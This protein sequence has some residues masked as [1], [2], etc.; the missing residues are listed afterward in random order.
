M[1]SNT[2]QKYIHKIR[3]LRIDKAHGN[4]PHQPVLLL[5]II[6]LIEQG[7]IL[8]NKITLSP[9]LVETFVKYWTKITDRKPNLALPF[10]HL[11]KRPFWHLHANPGYENAL[12]VVTQIKTVTRLRKVVAYASFDDEFFVLL[13]KPKEREIFRQTIISTYLSDFKHEIQSLIL[14]EQ[15]ISEYSQ[16]ILQQVEHEFIALQQTA[17]SESENPV[18]KRGFR[19]AIMRIYEYT[20]AVCQLHILTLD[21]QSVTEAAHIIPHKK[22]YNND[23]RNGISLCRLHHW[24]F[25]EGLISFNDNYKVIVSELMSER[26]PTEWL[27]STLH[28]QSILLPENNELYP[29]Q[30]AL[31]WHREEVFRR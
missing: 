11:S 16:K 27:L 5:A 10:F 29:A 8:D 1:F 9:G 12:E 18:R 19:L 13:G 31:A 2:L 28:D 15:Q 4:A 21:G 23:V 14:E 20:C 24:A 6:E 30:E 17:S 22:S 26:G 25:D 3:N 7:Q